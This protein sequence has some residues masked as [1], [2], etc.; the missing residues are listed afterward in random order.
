MRNLLPAGVLGLALVLGAPALAPAQSDQD[1]LE[2]HGATDSG[3]PVVAKDAFA[4]S[5]H[6]TVGC[7][8]CHA[9]AA[10]YPHPDAMPRP[11]CADC[12][13][14]AGEQHARSAHGRAR[15][16]GDEEAPG[17]AACHASAHV[18]R[19]PADAQSQ[20][21]PANLPRT[22]GA[23]HSNPAMVARHDIGVAD[24]VAQYLD[25]IHGQ[26]VTRKG[27][28]VAAN[29]STCH[30]AHEIRAAE[31]PASGVHHR[32]VPETCG[33]CHS[34]VL[35]TY[36]GSVHGQKLRQGDL[37]AAVCSDCHAPHFIRPAAN[38]DWRLDVVRECGTCHEA[39]LRTYRDTFHGQVSELGY[40][41]VARCSDC[42]GSHD[43]LPKDAAGSRVAGANLVKTC[44]TC[45]PG[46]N[47]NFVRYDPHADPHDRRR[48][49]GYWLVATF[50]KSLLWT[51]FAFFGLH[52]ALWGYRSWREHGGAARGGDAP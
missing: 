5:A 27:D 1:C 21:H 4:A 34:D 31:D 3:A 42:H 19:R 10:E 46:A 51:V 9:G 37:R 28:L 29:C 8:T 41:R 17:C 36:A 38:E 43:I 24:P 25:S 18:A 48:N 30:G 49:P 13:P 20:V 47:A 12:H 14:E 35:A 2:C 32:N 22:C 50:M 45:H 16:R 7:A 23:C 15:A 33:Q 6:A 52:T 11:A 39:A 26:A 40:T 44:A